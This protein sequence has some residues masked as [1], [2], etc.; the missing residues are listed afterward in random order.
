MEE[1]SQVPL[2]PLPPDIRAGRKPCPTK[3]NCWE[4][5]VTFGG[6][7]QSDVC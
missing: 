1:E 6:W 5:T 3:T 4:A 7:G 2:E